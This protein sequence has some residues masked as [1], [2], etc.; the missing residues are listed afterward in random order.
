MRSE[1]A[2]DRVIR[3]SGDSQAIRLGHSP[4]GVTLAVRVIPRAG[5]TTIAGVRSGALTVR[6]AAA[7]VDGEANDAL[8]AFLAKTFNLP[9]RDIT[10]VS[11]HTSRDKRIALAG[12]S[13]TQVAARL[14]DILSA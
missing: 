3:E 8:M 7:P 4:A 14:D 10:I 13:E 9:R 11:G 1:E 12:L 2:G 5:R 6:L